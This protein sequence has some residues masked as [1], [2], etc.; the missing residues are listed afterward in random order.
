MKGGWNEMRPIGRVR[1]PFKETREIP[2]GPGAKHDAE[3]VLEILPELEPG[4]TDIEGFSHLYVIWVFDRADSVE[5]T[6]TPP[7]D[8]R[9]HGV[10]ATRSPFRP[11]PIGLTVV[12]LLRRDGPRL[13]VRGVDM[14]NETPILDIKPYLSSVAPEALRRGW[15]EEAERRKR[16][17]AG[18]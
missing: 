4:L 11:N 14:L 18:E 1:S 2:K 7:C 8:D 6:G 13:H 9:P 10:F 3:G 12:E 16:A 5:L 17:R 15:M